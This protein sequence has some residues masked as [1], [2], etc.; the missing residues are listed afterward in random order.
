MKLEIN[1]LTWTDRRGALKEKL[2]FALVA[3]LHGSPFDDLME[4]MAEAGLILVAGDIPN[5]HRHRPQPLAEAFLR[6]AP[7]L[8][9]VYYALGNHERKMRGAD[10][11]I[12]RV[13]DAGIQ[14][15]DNRAVALRPDV[16]LG[17]LSSQPRIRPDQ[18]DTSVV[19]ALAAFD[20]FRLLLCHHPEYYPRYVAGRGVD[21]TLSGHAHGGQVRIAGQ[22]LYA[23]GQWLFPRYTSGWY[24]DGH[25]LVSRGLSNHALVPRINNP[26]ELIILTLLPG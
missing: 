10:E 13:R 17:G 22:G 18:R 2:T 6:E 24:D 20:G 25:L 15:L 19:D 11:W 9:P 4:A 16:M 3:D 7:R 23:P 5:R 8:A 14:L 1:R 12:R 21:L 26:C